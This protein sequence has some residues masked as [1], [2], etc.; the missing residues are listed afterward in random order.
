MG[1][2]ESANK[3]ITK[4]QNKVQGFNSRL[5]LVL[6][7]LLG[8][9]SIPLLIGVTAG[10][11]KSIATFEQGYLRLFIAGIVAYLILHLFIY[12]PVAVYKFG[13]SVLQFIFGFFAPLVKVASYLLPVYTLLIIAA[14]FI[15]RDIFKSAPD[16]ST[17]LFF[18][19]FSFTFH[20]V[21][22]AD[23]LR[24]KEAGLGRANYFFAFSLIYL[25]TMVMLAG[26]LH[27]MLSDF[28]F[29]DFLDQSGRE[30]WQ[31]YERVFSQLFV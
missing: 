22:T 25:L 19:A 7:L 21:L 11:S 16:I 24:D 15:L 9:L 31:V 13:Q 6:K 27:F 20:L 12:K 17:F 10:F 3:T 30:V 14:F 26:G 4:I 8:T 5:I 28:S 23:A 2:K 18:I 1:K 29:L